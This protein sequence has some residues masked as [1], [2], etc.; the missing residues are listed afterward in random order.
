MS[1]SLC[2]RIMSTLTLADMNVLLYRCD[3]EERAEG[4]GCYNVPSWVPLKYGGLQGTQNSPTPDPVL[5]L[6]DL[7]S[8][9]IVL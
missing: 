1:V 8:L 7:C 6:R 3:A 4:G 9:G 5:R 2:V